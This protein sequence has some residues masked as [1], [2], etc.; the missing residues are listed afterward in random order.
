VS[1]SRDALHKPYRKGHLDRSR[2]PQRRCSG[3]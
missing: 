2:S 1:D 3:L